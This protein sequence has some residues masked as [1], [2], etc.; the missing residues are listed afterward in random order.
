[1]FGITNWWLFLTTAL[2]LNAT[3]GA[4]VIFVLT[5][6]FRSGMSGALKSSVG[7]AVGY[8]LYVFLTFAG[9]TI[10]LERFPV[11]LSVIKISGGFYLM[12]LGINT[13]KNRHNSNFSINELPVTQDRNLF[14]KGFWVSALN[15]KVGLFFLSFLPQFIDKSHQNN[16]GIVVLGTIFCIG[17]TL[18][19]LGY[20]FIFSRIQI[21]SNHKK[22]ISIIS[23]A[24]LIA[25]G[26]IVLIK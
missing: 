18:F 11:I 24:V 13:F 16:Y 9:L 19:N 21:G 23:G 22:Y 12:Y 2:I 14:V 20:C 17:A 8:L 10:I 26:V 3:P 5:N 7:L 15:P 1:M 4:D 6:F 25:L